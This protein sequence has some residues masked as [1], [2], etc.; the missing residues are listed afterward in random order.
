MDYNLINVYWAIHIKQRFIVIIFVRTNISCSWYRLHVEYCITENPYQI[1][2]LTKS[3]SPRWLIWYRRNTIMVPK[4]FW[5]DCRFLIIVRTVFWYLYIFLYF[6]W[7][8]N[9]IFY[10]F[11]HKIVLKKILKK[12]IIIIS[13]TSLVYILISKSCFLISPGYYWTYESVCFTWPIFG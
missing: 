12:L 7:Y 11:A 13:R 8:N 6:I 2:F 10:T 4:Q 3:I 5:E 1:L 9:F